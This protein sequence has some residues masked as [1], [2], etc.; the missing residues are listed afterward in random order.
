MTPDASTLAAMAPALARSSGLAPE[1]IRSELERLLAAPRP[2][3]GFE[4]LREGG[5]L[6]RVLPELAAC[7]GV[8]QN[9]YHAYD[10]YRHTLA[11]VDAAPPSSRIVRWAALLHDIGKPG[12]RAGS[13]GAATFHGHERLGADLARR[14]LEALRFPQADTERIVHLVREHM[15]D[16]HEGW[17]DAA[18]RRWVRRVGEPA[19][20]DLM[21]LRRAD[22]EG[23]GLPPHDSGE[24][25]QAFLARIESVL[26]SGRVLH[27]RDLPVSGEDVMR[28]LGC[29][30]GPRVGEV[31]DR[32]LEHAIEDPA[33]ATREALLARIESSAEPGPEEPA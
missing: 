10:V 9:R 25:T 31:L 14:R 24:P 30:P 5:W 28:V 33:N 2:S 22:A 23:A 21:R 13:E 4:V 17:G 3:V 11:T 15:F 6:G 16:Y 26:A 18:V 29:A 7:I 32:L 20:G 12:T 1:R 27:V 8:T 19:I